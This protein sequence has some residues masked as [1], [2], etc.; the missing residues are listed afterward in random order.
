MKKTL[1]KKLLRKLL[2]K[3]KIIILHGPPAGGK[4][5]QQ[6]LLEKQIKKANKD[7]VVATFDMGTRLREISKDENHVLA[8]A[9]KEFTSDRELACIFTIF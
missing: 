7:Y 8:N 3:I 1:T 4:G 6:D 5:M 2:N 9:F